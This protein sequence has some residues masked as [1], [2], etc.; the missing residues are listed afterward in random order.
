MTHTAFHN[1]ANLRD[2]FWS[3]ILNVGI[4]ER[5]SIEINLVYFTNLVSF[6]KLNERK[7]GRVVNIPRKRGAF[8][9]TRSKSVLPVGTNR[10]DI[11]MIHWDNEA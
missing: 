3:Y 10:R 9:C 7:R 2:L 6:I 11:G 5:T 1:S 8:A 4:N